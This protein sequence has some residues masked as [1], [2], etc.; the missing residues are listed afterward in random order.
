MHAM[1]LLDWGRI[2]SIEFRSLY[3][4]KWHG[5]FC[6]PVS[7]R[8]G[9]VLSPEGAFMKVL[10]QQVDTW[11]AVCSFDAVPIEPVEFAIVG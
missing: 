10:K 9:A 2:P 6:C 5:L 8:F 7:I 11:A 4:C 3:L 1:A